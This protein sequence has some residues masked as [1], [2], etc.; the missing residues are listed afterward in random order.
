MDYSII[1]SIEAEKDTSDG[2]VYYEDQHPGLG[3]RFLA[4]LTRFYQKLEKIQLTI[5]LSQ[6][7]K[8]FVPCL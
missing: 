5:R 2:Y 6:N 8:Q 7:E 4:E 3:D 1:I